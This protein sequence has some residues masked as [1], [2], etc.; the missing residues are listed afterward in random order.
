MF[1][2]FFIYFNHNSRHL[3][4][5]RPGSIGTCLSFPGLLGQGRG[6]RHPQGELCAGIPQRPGGPHTHGWA[7][8]PCLQTKVGYILVRNHN[9]YSFFR[10]TGSRLAPPSYTDSVLNQSEQAA[11]QENF[12]T[13]RGFTPQYSYT[14]RL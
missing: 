5:P 1:H 14:N 4:K 3:S 9:F 6:Q 11:F 12:S 7:H 13:T 2:V 8:C 10:I